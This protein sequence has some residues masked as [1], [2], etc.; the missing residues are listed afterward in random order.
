MENMVPPR[1]D[2][3]GLLSGVTSPQQEY[4]PFKF[5]AKPG[6]HRICKSLPPFVLVAPGLVSTHRKGGVEQQDTLSGPALQVAAARVRRPGI[7]FYF[8]ENIDEGRRVRQ[9][10]T[11]RK[12][13]AMCLPRPVIRVLANQYHLDFAGK[14][15]RKCSENLAP[16][17]ITGVYSIF[18]PN[19]VS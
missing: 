5:L 18:L 14:A 17:G 11:H 2:E 13:K 3:P 6:D 7:P 15:M 4:Q 8:A 9:A 10:F 19:E 12:T 16:A 1:I